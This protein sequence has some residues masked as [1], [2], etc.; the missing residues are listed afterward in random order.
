MMR[1]CD[2]RQIVLAGLL[3]VGA[4]CTRHPAASGQVEDSPYVPAGYRLVWHDEFESEAKALPDT[5]KWRYEVGGGGWGNGE[6]QYYAP[7]VWGKDTVAFVEGGI[8][9]I[10]ALTPETPVE[11]HRYLSARMNSRE[12]W[13]YGYFEARLKMPVGRGTWPAFWMLPE[14]MKSWP[15]DGEIDIMEHVGSHP[16]S[17]LVTVHTQKYNHMIG[18][19]K[20]VQ[21]YIPHTQSEFHLYAL[22]WT[23]QAITGYI[24][25]KRYF[26]YPNEEN[27]GK[28]A[29]PFDAP[30]R[31]LLNQAIGG[32]LGGREGVDDACFPAVYQADYIRVYQ[33]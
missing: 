3:V 15:L 19:Q 30:F 18:T 33:K 20:G 25:G 31:L 21:I 23:E 1:T 16:D 24:D 4:S 22:E 26:S 6:L 10:V 14:N 27:G 8:L 9:N 13:K 2:L 17:I 7:A 29:W 32:G 11:G 28:E 12:S 5:L